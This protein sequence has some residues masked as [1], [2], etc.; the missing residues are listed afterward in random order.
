MQKAINNDMKKMILK[1]VLALFVVLLSSPVVSNAQ[2]PD[3][4]DTNVPTNP[5]A[6]QLL[7]QVL[8]NRFSNFSAI[9]SKDMIRSLDFCIAD[10]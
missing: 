6:A 9:L 7:S 1:L 5:A 10:V 8:F 2:A 4:E 3:G